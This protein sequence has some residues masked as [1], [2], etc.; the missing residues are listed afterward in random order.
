MSRG[1]GTYG[2]RGRLGD[3]HSGIRQTAPTYGK[4]R[5]GTYAEKAQG[6]INVESDAERFIAHLLEIDPRVTAFQPQPFTVDLIDA[7]LLT[8][9]KEVWAARRAYHDMPGP[10]L[11]TPDFSFAWEDG[12]TH[13]CEVKTEGYLGD[14]EY[15]QKLERAGVILGAH[16]HG[17]YTLVMPA[18]TA[19][20]L[21]RN[22]P[23]LKQAQR[24]CSTY[25]TKELAERV[26]AFCERGPVTAQVLCSALE[27]PTGLIPIFLVSGLLSADLAHQPICGA[28]EVSLAYGVLDHLCLLHEVMQ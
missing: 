13:V 24:Q 27:L 12:F 22:V 9:P 10:R 19:H 25:L 5:R 18:N 6:H 16:N 11:Y 20:P 1:S 14:S 28:L 23:L 4:A 8:T 21:R 7:S 15:Q 2:R 3:A 26:E 17:F